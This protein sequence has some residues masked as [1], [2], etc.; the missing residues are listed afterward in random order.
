MPVVMVW[1][2]IVWYGMAWYPY[3]QP[4]QQYWLGNKDSS[5]ALTA[6]AP[7]THTDIYKSLLNLQGT[8]MQLLFDMLPCSLSFHKNPQRQ[9]KYICRCS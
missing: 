9:C 7:Y 5:H 6:A 2:Y 1:F 4:K 3:R 8:F